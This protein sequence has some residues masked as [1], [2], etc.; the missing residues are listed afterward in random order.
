MAEKLLT[1]QMINVFIGTLKRDTL[2]QSEATQK[3][4]I[5]AQQEGIDLQ[6]YSDYKFVLGRY[7]CPNPED[8]NVDG[9]YDRLS[10]AM[11]RILIISLYNR[12]IV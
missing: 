2:S 10:M 4:E 12:A 5:F 8:G 1:M 11:N 6:R 7:Y 3:F 9:M